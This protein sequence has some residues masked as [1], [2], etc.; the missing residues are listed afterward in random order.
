[1]AKVFDQVNGVVVYGRIQM[2]RGSV[3][4]EFSQ[5]DTR[6]WIISKDGLFTTA[7]YLISH[8]TNASGVAWSKATLEASFPAFCEKP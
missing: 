1:M 3:I 7:R 2:P 5:D 8:L 4:I 6:V